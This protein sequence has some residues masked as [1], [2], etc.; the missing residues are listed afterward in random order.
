MIAEREATEVRR[1]PGAMGWGLCLLLA[2]CLHAGAAAFLMK[3]TNSFGMVASA[4]VIMIELAEVA[5]A[6]DVVPTDVPPGPEQPEAQAQ[7]QP[8]KPVEKIEM[9]ADLAKEA[10]L[11]ETP[12]AP[13]EKVK[14]KKE[15]QQHARLVS[16]P[17]T[18]E[19]R[20]ERTAAQAPGAPSRNSNALPTWISA[21]VARIERY[22]RPA[23]AQ[24]RGETGVTRLAFSVDRAGGVHGAR[25]VRSSGSSTLDRETLALVERAAPMPAPPPEVAGTQIPI[26]VPIRY[27]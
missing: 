15:K 18:A 22:K 26:E 2:L 17:S 1:W 13:P 25:I 7:S 21:M 27:R 14:E 20:A 8:E 3:W 10:E 24:S 23:D 16:S 19:R 5:V 6:P 4:P 11:P 9:K 12:P